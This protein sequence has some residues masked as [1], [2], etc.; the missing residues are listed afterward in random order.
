[1]KRFKAVVIHCLANV[2]EVIANSKEEAE[3]KIK[4]IDNSTD[5]ISQLENTKMFPVYKV[6]EADSE[7]ED[8]DTDDTQTVSD[9]EE[10]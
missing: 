2:V 1:M 3:A 4:D 9:D 7:S 10:V 8:C 6:F 5:V